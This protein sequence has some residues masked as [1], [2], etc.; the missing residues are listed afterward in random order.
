MGGVGPG[1]PGGSSGSTGPAIISEFIIPKSL[2][3]PVV[4]AVAVVETVV[5]IFMHIFSIFM[6]GESKKAEAAISLLAVIIRLCV[7]S[8][9]KF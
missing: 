7:K 1:G 6:T 8:I 2:F 3:C 4:D 5:A 9:C